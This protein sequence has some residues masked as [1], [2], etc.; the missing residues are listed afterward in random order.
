[1]TRRQWRELRALVLSG[2]VRATG[3]RGY[4]EADFQPLQVDDIVHALERCGDWARQGAVKEF[5]AWHAEQKRQREIYF[6][7]ARGLRRQWSLYEARRAR[8]SRLKIAIAEVEALAH[9]V[10]YFGDA[11]AGKGSE[12]RSIAARLLGHY[13]LQA[14]RGVDERK[15]RKPRLSLGKEESPAIDVLS[16]WLALIL[17]PHGIKPPDRDNLVRILRRGEEKRRRTM[18]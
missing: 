7:T 5:R 17:K 12:G 13:L 16:E 15:G 18:S 8:L 9:S 4:A 1:M 11:F 2:L 6:E 10:V 14:L 3:S